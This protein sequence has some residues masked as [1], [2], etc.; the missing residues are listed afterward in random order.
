MELMKMVLKLESKTK[1]LNY[2]GL[3]KTESSYLA[4]YWLESMMTELNCLGQQ[5]KESSYSVMN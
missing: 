1:D 5:K 4:M 3:M 2:L